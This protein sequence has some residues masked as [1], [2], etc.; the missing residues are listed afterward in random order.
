MAD[1]VEIASVPETR[2]QAAPVNS[3]P[4]P[5][6]PPDHAHSRKMASGW[7]LLI[8]GAVILLAIGGFL[9]W[10]H[11][12]TYE[13]TDDA[14]VDA[15]IHP[16]SARVSGYVIDV[17]VNDNQYVQK[18]TVLV[19]I[20]PRD[21]QVAVDR[22]R[23]DL[24]DAQAKA[25]EAGIH[26]PLTGVNTS[27]SLETAQAGVENAAD[28]IKTEQEQASAADDTLKEAQANDV[29]AQNDLKRYRQLV[30]E[31]EIS[32]QQYDQAVASAQGSTASVAQARA[33]AE[34]AHEKIAGA[35]AKLIEAQASRKQ[36]QT[37]PQ[38]VATQRSEAESQ[39]AKA[40][41]KRAVL[42]QAELNLQYTTIVAPVNGIVYR[43]VEPGQN[44]QP[45]QELISVVPV[46]DVF[47]T[48]NFKE[49]QLQHMRVGQRAVIRVDAYSR[50]YNG[51]VESIAGAS[52][53]SFSLLPAEN[54]TG[55][56]VKVVQR[57]P[58][59]IVL[60]SGQNDD[61]LLRVGMSVEPKVYVK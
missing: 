54:A 22:A 13:S 28:E 31:Q 39:S 35:H 16:I 50:D 25:R 18:G 23:A 12:S 15:H 24:A 49:T 52:G 14:Q 8:I 38:Q 47:V 42:E 17:P 32:R 40:D 19:R 27:T 53:D 46:D 48:A 45:G 9:L 26:V 58:V 6:A 41:E 59:K 10:R 11:L 5:S 30:D 33:S 1:Q 36:A 3:A 57:V 37:G 43:K 4:P 2:E 60:D 61:H 21:Y 34:A 51:K 44:V 7:R 55:N 56:Y 20:D 29:K